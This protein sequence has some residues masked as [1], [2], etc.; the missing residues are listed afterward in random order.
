M[1]ILNNITLI[2]A[3]DIKLSDTFQSLNN[4]KKHI[5]FNRVVLFTSKPVKPDNGIDVI[6]V[7]PITCSKD[8][9]KFIMYELHKHIT[10]SHCL[11]TQHD[12]WIVNHDKW[13]DAFLKYDYIGAPWPSGKVGNGGF[14]LRTKRFLEYFDK[15]NKPYVPNGDNLYLEDSIITTV[16]YEDLLKDGI[17]FAPERLANE[18]SREVYYKNS[19]QAPF[20]FH[21]FR[22]ANFIYLNH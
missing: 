14:S 2:A 5:V 20:G 22:D 1:R 6:R 21:S 10:T 12:G 11:I 18:F 16:Y 19:V 15:N 17:T 8:Y 3:S 4:S 13:N 7:D 9:S